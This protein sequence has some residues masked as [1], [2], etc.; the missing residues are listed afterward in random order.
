MC[1]LVFDSK[2]I[3]QLGTRGGQMDV[4]TYCLYSARERVR[5]S[6]LFV[7]DYYLDLDFPQGRTGRS[8]SFL[9]CVSVC[10]RREEQDSGAGGREVPSVRPS[11]TL[12]ER[13]HHLFHPPRWRERA[14]VV[15]PQHDGEQD[16]LPLRSPHTP[17]PPAYLR[18]AGKYDLFVP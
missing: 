1:M 12:R 8:Q 4:A 15:P 14:H 11:V 7:S 10:A 5:L 18:A 3:V 16:S 9:V 6:E 13:P 2:V 17:A